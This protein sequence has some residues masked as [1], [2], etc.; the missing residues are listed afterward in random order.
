M[1]RLATSAPTTPL[2]DRILALARGSSPLVDE[3]LR[4]YGDRTLSDYLATIAASRA[5]SLQDREDL[6]ETVE[7]EA[8]ASCGPEAAAEVVADL[9]ADPIVPTSNHFGI[10][11][12]AESVQGT[13]LFSLRPG[14]TR[15]SRT[16]LV[17]GFGSISMNNDFSYPMGLLLYDPSQ[18][19]LEHLPQRLPIFPGRVKQRAVC[20]VEPFDE[21]M[22]QRAQARLRRMAED[23]DVTPFCARAAGEILE[24]VFAAPATLGLPSYR[25]Q[26]AAVNGELWRRIFS[27]RSHA[28]E[29]VQLQIEPI[30]AALLRRDLG[31][32]RSLLHRLFF[33][34]EVRERLLAELDGGRACWRRADLEHRLGEPAPG[35]ARGC[36]TVFFWG[37][38][39]SGRRIPLALEARGSGLVLAGT[40]DGGQAWET[41]WSAEGILADLEAGRLLPSLFTCFTVLAFARGLSCVGGYYQ[42]EY[43]PAMKAG[44]VEALSVAAEHREAAEL[45]AQA[46]SSICLAALQWLVRELDDGSV[47]P[48]GP[49]ELAGMGG[50]G[51]SELAAVE[52]VSVRE[53]YLVALTELF[54]QLVSG[55]DLPD[56]WV[57]RLALENGERRRKRLR[58]VV[59]RPPHQS[60]SRKR[61][62]V[63]T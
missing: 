29:L 16:A 43:L 31:D 9:R 39:D 24:E 36:G 51:R 42:A 41:E 3:T 25:R 33:V 54:D 35:A 26:A 22:V 15:R 10:D 32:E 12:A 37:L 5:P 17:L 23:G 18:G 13:L 28:G 63:P 60:S 56:G 27:D 49:I 52:S 57:S 45:V 50:L 11:T 2:G 7:A 1:S 20:A 38:S 8:T 47:V 6:W 44:I 40:S 21:Q 48:A 14:R 59:T 19:R 46:P 34:D 55:A 30:C 62:G 58:A 53:A 61:I 4:R